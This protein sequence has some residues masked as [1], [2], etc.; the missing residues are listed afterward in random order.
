M[1]VYVDMHY[2][3]ACYIYIYICTHT[4]YICYTYYIYIYVHTIYSI[5]IYIYV[6]ACMHMHIRLH[7]HIHGHKYIHYTF[8]LHHSSTRTY[9]PK[10]RIQEKGN[11]TWRPKGTSLNRATKEKH[12]QVGGSW[13]GVQGVL[14]RWGW[15]RLT[16]RQS[17]VFCTQRQWS[18]TRHFICIHMAMGQKPVPP[19]NIPIPTKIGSKMGGAPKT[20]KMVPLVLTH[21]HIYI[22]I[23]IHTHTYIYIYICTHLG[24][25]FPEGIQRRAQGLPLQPRFTLAGRFCVAPP[26]LA[27]GALPLGPRGGISMGAGIASGC[28]QPLGDTW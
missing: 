1:N 24:S 15:G 5:Y 28:L 25:L 6:Y 2:I 27:D 19:V 23:C 7:V 26:L 22:Y 21:S 20:P 16:L 13:P 4:I 17:E 3:Y 14:R 18:K 11:L 12:T 8:T 9:P 10:H